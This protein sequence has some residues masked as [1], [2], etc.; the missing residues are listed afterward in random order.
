MLPLRMLVLDVRPPIVRKRV[1]EGRAGRQCIG[2][3]IVWINQRAR[4]ASILQIEIIDRGKRVHPSVLRQ[5]V[6]IKTNA[7]A[8]YSS[9]GS[10]RLV[11]DSQPRRKSPSIIV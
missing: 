5:I 9:R 7:S 1:L 4:P 2:R 6:V 8:Q 10:V 11:T 3:V